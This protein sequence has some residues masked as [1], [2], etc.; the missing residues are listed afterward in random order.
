MQKNDGYWDCRD[1][2]PRGPQAEFGGNVRFL[3]PES[4]RM[5]DSEGKVINC[6]CGKPAG[7]AAMGK[8]AFVAWCSDCSPLHKEE[9]ELAYRP[10][11]EEQKAKLKD[12][13]FKILEDA[14]TI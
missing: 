12:M 8:E 10:P 3:N 9:A 4:V 11:S 2:K 6:K 5:Y 14:W 7:S 13:G 1:V